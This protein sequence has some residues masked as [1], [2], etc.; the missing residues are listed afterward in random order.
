TAPPQGKSRCS[1]AT[2]PPER[3]HP[4]P[5]S[6][7]ANTPNASSSAPT[8]P[9]S[10]QPTRPPTPSRNTPATA[11]PGS[12]PR[13]APPPSQPEQTP[14]ASQSAPTATTSTPPTTAPTQ[15]PNTHGATS[16]DYRASPR[17]DVPRGK[18]L[19]RVQR[20]AALLI[21]HT[22]SARTRTGSRSARPPGI[23]AP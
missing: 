21:S 4:P 10:T 19:R 11:K 13:S 6:R 3:S 9:T 14:K 1:R 22:S 18:A 7:Q 12:S 2:R 20:R 17:V 15:S 8:E 23:E 16:S 5:P